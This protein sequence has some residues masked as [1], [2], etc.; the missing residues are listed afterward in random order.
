[1]GN[2]TNLFG[3]QTVHREEH[4]PLKAA[5]DGEQVRQGYGAFIKLEGTKDPHGSQHTELSHCSDGE[6]PA[7]GN[8]DSCRSLLWRSV[9]G[10]W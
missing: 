3:E 7:G 8:R 1:M 4:H 5:K 10:L 6:C 9:Q 2:A